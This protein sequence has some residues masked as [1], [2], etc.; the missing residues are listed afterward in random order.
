MPKRYWRSDTI[1]RAPATERLLSAAV[2]EIAAVGV[3]S[4]A[5]NS[6][7]RRAGVARSTLYNHF[8]DTGDLLAELWVK[9]GAAW[10]DRL[11]HDS[12]FGL[13]ER[14]LDL[15]MLELFAVAHRFRELGG[16][17][18]ESTQ[19]W[20]R[21]LCSDEAGEFRAM[22]LVGNR[23]GVELSRP[24]TPMVDRAYLTLDFLE[25]LSRPNLRD[26]SQ[27]R[28]TGTRPAAGNII[29]GSTGLVLVGDPFVYFDGTDERLL[30]AAIKVIANHG[31]ANASIARI[32][33]RAGVTKG[34]VYPRFADAKSI[35]SRGFALS[36]ARVVTANTQSLIEVGLGP[37]TLT[38][39]AL[40]ALT[41]ERE[42]WRDFRT[43]LHVAARRNAELA[44]E[45]AGA[46]ELTRLALSSVAENFTSDPEYVYALT[47]SMQATSLGW[48]LLFAN[49]V[50]LTRVD[51]PLLFGELAG[52][53]LANETRSRF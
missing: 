17:V 24:V 50:D 35:V 43:E 16:L 46:F 32:A 15:A 53:V 8:E 34:S 51:Y 22:W 25:V 20:W 11:A 39:V 31:V 3:D 4:L 10:L 1:S 7:S 18:R 41:P 44:A 30:L 23:L 19:L 2:E 33:R 26:K 52:F 27:P 12:D 42:I 6:I 13:T 45:M 47:Q 37:D 14:N 48:P 40:N 28:F 29:E 49:G 9:E 36:L 21:R 5:V 38:E